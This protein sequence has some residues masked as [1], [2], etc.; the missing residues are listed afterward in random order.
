MITFVLSVIS[1]LFSLHTHSFEISNSITDFYL[2]IYTRVIIALSYIHSITHLFK[3][4]ISSQNFPS[5]SGQSHIP[6]LQ[7][8]NNIFN[9]NRIGQINFASF[10]LSS[11]KNRQ[12]RNFKYFMHQQSILSIIFRT[13]ALPHTKIDKDFY[14]SS[15]SYFFK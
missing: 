14:L 13:Y 15:S 3:F 4:S 10:L 12:L 2:P 6:S 1:V 8:S 7:L 9:L 11:R 5:I